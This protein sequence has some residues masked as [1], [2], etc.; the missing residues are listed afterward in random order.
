MDKQQGLYSISYTAEINT[1]L[2]I[3]CTSIKKKIGIWRAV[4]NLWNLILFIFYICGHTQGMWD[5]FPNQESNPQPLRWKGG[6]LT[7][8][9]P[10]KSWSVRTELNFRTPSCCPGISWCVDNPLHTLNWV[11]EFQYY[12]HPLAW[13]LPVIASGLPLLPWIPK[14]GGARVPYLKWPRI[15]ITYSYLPVYMTSPPDYV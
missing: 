7:A 4:L 5:P 12:S 2:S 6:L 10:G 3:N 13:Y 1:T 8:R 14:S 11:V 9:E 15:C